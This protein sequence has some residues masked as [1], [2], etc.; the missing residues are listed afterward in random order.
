[1]KKLL[2]CAVLLASPFAFA[3][4]WDIDAA[5]ASGNFSVRHMMVSNVK[6]TLGKV[7]GKVELDDADITK[8][9]V[10]VSIDVKG[11][12]TREQ[13]RDDHLR[14]KDFFDVEKFPAITFKS[15]KIEKAGDKLKVTGDLT[16]RGATKPV[17]LDVTLTPEVKNPFSKATTRGVTGTAKLN[18]KDFGLTWNVA[19]EAGGVLVGDDVE[20]SVEAELVK[21]EAPAAPA[22]K[23]K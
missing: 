9:K 22:A 12:N 18:R 23:K 6:G 16:I 13:K 1:M 4:T 20:I 8:S 21:Q 17:V 11:I 19:L 14:S 3:S 2:V 10:E 7:T 5:H 15:T